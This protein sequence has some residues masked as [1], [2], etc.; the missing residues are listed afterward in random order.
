MKALTGMIMFLMW[1]SLGNSCFALDDESIAGEVMA[2]EQAF[3]DTMKHRDFDAFRDFLSEEAIF[4]AGDEP[5]RGKETVAAAWRGF[6]QQPEPP[7]SWKP[8]QVQVLE[9]GTLA[10]STGP[11]F[12]PK[13]EQTAT[14]T[15]IWRK[16]SSG[17]WRI[18]FDKG[19]AHC[20]TTQ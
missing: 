7:F 4:F 11:V 3:A 10:L 1:F 18:V 12:N 16:E 15:S 14:F 6:Y 8:Q 13:G 5:L 20:Q 19:A 2:V 9:S 17:E